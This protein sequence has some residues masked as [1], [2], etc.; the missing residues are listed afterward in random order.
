MR[1]SQIPSTNN[2]TMTDSA[3]TQTQD[4]K[5]IPRFGDSDSARWNLFGIWGLDIGI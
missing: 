5:E 3:P 1:K 4:R 2:Q